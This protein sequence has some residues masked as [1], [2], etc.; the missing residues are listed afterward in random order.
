MFRALCA[1]HQEVKTV[2]YSIWYHHT[3]RWPSGTQVERGLHGT[4][5]YRCDDTRCCI[6]QFW[7]PDDEHICSKHVGAW[8]KTYC[9][10][11]M[12]CIKL[13]N[14]WDKYTEMQHGQQ[15][16]KKLNLCFLVWSDLHHKVHTCVKSKY[17]W[18][19]LCI[20]NGVLYFYPP[21]FSTLILQA[22]F[23]TSV[24]LWLPQIG[25]NFLP[26]KHAK[27]V[28]PF[29]SQIRWASLSNPF[30]QS[31]WTTCIPF[32]VTPHGLVK[33]NTDVSEDTWSF[34]ISVT[35]DM[36]RLKTRIHSEKC[37]VVRTCTYKSLDSIAYYTPRLCGT[38]Y[39]S[40]ATNLYSMLLYWILWTTVTQWYY[41]I[42]L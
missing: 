41:N 35:I 37:V 39:C 14:Y 23:V 31:S 4:A 20:C 17:F 7:P 8:N 12:L 9:E 32:A 6:I 36:H 42:I 25:P 40:W 5:T 15:N 13:V 34:D 1:H 30:A 3:C 33:K 10:T 26:S 28:R 11:K 19:T 16:V 38:A 29:P 2:L 24:A 27:R 22:S 21:P 18:K